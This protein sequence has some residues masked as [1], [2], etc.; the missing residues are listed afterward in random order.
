MDP[1]RLRR[2]PHWR[3]MLLACGLP[4]LIAPAAFQCAD[5][6]EGFEAK[7]SGRL[8]IGSSYRTEATDPLLVTASNAAAAGIAGLA[9]TVNADDA[10]LNFR[11][12][13]ATSTVVK[14]YLDLD[15]VNGDFSALVRV[16]A[17]YDYAL[18]R[19]PRPWGN[20]ANGYTA[21]VPLSDA[22]F[23]A[24]SRFSGVALADAFIA[25][26]FIVDGM[27][28]TARAGQ[29][30]INWGERVSFG[31]G[32]Q[33][34]ATIDQPASHRPGAVPQE[35]RLPVPAMFGRLQLNPA[36]AVE[37]Y[38]QTAERHNA[39]D[40]CGTFFSA[41]DYVVDGCD[42]LFAGAPAGSDRL[43]L[44]A[45]AYVKRTDNPFAD[46][47]RQFGIASTFKAPAL[48]TEFGLYHARMNA[49]VPVPGG[50]KST[51]LGLPLI[52]GDADGKNVRYFMETPQGISL[53]AL[54]FASKR[55]QGLLYGEFSYRPNLPVSLSAGDVLAAF[56]SPTAA[57]LIRSDITAL[58]PGGAY[59]TY[60]RFKT[61]QAQ[62]GIV[63][64]WV[65][66]TGLALTA[67]GEV[68]WKHVVS[69][70]NP[71]I[72]RYG[73]ADVFGQG[74]VAGVCTPTAPNAA[75][76]CSLDGYV[77]PNAWAYRLKLDTRLPA[78][79]NGLVLAPSLSFTHDVKGWSYDGQINEKRQSANLALRAEYRQRYV[80]ELVFTP[81][82]G[83][84]YNA[85]S[86]RDLFS[87]SVGIKF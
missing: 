87:I 80:A 71:A 40:G 30:N 77:T 21:G 10:N 62:L 6:A 56:I 12:N 69:L 81:S 57:S 17:W 31:G 50:I 79:V 28:L 13:D 18:A 11:R 51:R 3:T 20:A 74:P 84:D 25:G 34:L 54:S 8:T 37:A 23:P 7:L 72:R 36:I 64:E 70:P 26:R 45:G 42:K 60:D 2:A 29:Q 22:G 52:A 85:L 86:D 43:R 35:V 68:V 24:L 82:W 47:Q 44:A 58:A 5:A 39:I 67:G 53:T 38:V 32:L 75:K 4:L 49:R 73:R 46:D 63:Q 27:E 41:N 1:G 83:G 59:H 78:W 33:A 65:S 15:V 48:D 61:G 14:T 16:K 66:G 9:N 19:Q 55:E 76:Q